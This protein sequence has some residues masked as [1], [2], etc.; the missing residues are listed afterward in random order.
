MSP[1]AESL[2]DPTIMQLE[3]TIGYEHRR[4]AHAMT[5]V[6]GFHRCEKGH[7]VEAHPADAMRAAGQ[8]ANAMTA[9]HDNSHAQG[10]LQGDHGRTKYMKVHHPE[11]ISDLWNSPMHLRRRVFED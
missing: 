9:G 2:G 1:D 6:G 10:N 8:I 3:N 7:R 5:V 4:K 11:S